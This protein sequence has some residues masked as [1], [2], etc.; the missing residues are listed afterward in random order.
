MIHVAC[1]DM[2]AYRRAQDPTHKP[3]RVF[4]ETILANLISSYA[5]RPRDRDDSPS[6]P[7]PRQLLLAR[8]L[9]SDV[10]DVAGQ[11]VFDALAVSGGEVIH[12]GV[13]LGG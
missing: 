9:A 11:D 4:G 6:V 7:E 5:A 1:I 3:R 13:V 12:D 2:E 8:P 10:P